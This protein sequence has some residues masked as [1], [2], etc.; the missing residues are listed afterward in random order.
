VLIDKMDWGYGLALCLGWWD[1]Y[2]CVYGLG[3]CLG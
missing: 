3:L 2:M 1:G